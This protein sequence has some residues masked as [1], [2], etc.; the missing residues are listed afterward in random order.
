MEFCHSIKRIFK[1]KKFILLLISFG[2]HDG[3]YSA[4][5]TLLSQIVKP[6]FMGTND[7]DNIDRYIGLMGAVSMVV[8]G[9]LGSFVGGLV[10]DRYKKFKLT[11]LAAS[12]GSL[13]FIACFTGTVQLG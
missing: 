11:S 9:A 8:I 12:I 2:L 3:V 13:V 4:F 7:T 6:T 10:L 1:S 5:C